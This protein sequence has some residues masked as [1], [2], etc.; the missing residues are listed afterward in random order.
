MA[1]Y[2]IKISIHALRGEGDHS[3]Q[4]R[5]YARKDF[6]P[7][8]PWGG[9]PSGWTALSARCCIFLSTPS[10]G[11]ATLT[12]GTKNENIRYF[13]PRPPWGGRHFL[14]H[15]IGRCKKF[16]STPSVGRATRCAGREWPTG[17]ISI[18]ALRGEG[19]TCTPTQPPRASNFYP[20]PPWGGRL[21]LYCR[22]LSG[23]N[24]YPRPPWGGRPVRFICGNT[25]VL[26][27]STPSVG[28][29]TPHCSPFFPR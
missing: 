24:F 14:P 22:W 12:G 11:R 2:Y 29:A 4:I 10:V 5:P 17:R 27:L 15:H 21:G 23:C 25:N 19:D 1:S 9:R 16:L 13:Y 3:F 8:P 18:H 20:R 6:Y 7:R 26:F 28:R